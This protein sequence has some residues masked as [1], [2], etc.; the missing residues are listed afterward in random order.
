MFDR[1]FRRTA[2][3][4]PTP[5]Q[6]RA[7]LRPHHFVPLVGFVVPSAVIGYA[8][9]LPRAGVMG[10]NPL[11]LGFAATLIGAAV[12]YVVGVLVALRR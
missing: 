2:C 5:G 9:V 1:L 4:L 10:I 3:P 8:I 7:C 12:T 6:R 11:T